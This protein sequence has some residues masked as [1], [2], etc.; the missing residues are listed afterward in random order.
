[1]T[2]LAACL[3]AL[4]V[5]LLLA[6]AGTAAAQSGKSEAAQRE[7]KELRARIADLTAEQR[8]SERARGD[9]GR[10]LREADAAVDAAARALRGAE[11]ALSAAQAELEQL[12]AR[13]AT[14]E[15][16]LQKQRKALAALLRSR[17]VLGQRPRLQ[18]LLEQERLGDLARALAYQRYFERDRARRMT[19]L[20]GELQAL[21]A[22]VPQVQARRE[23]LALARDQQ[24]QAVDALAAQRRERSQAV[25]KL[26]A[27]YKDRKVRLAA[28]GR[29]ERATERLLSRLQ[30]AMKRRTT[31]A[32]VKATARRPGDAKVPVAA[33]L[34]LPLTGTVLAGFGGVMPDGHRS[35]GLLIA[36]AA[37]AEVRAVAAGRVAYADWLKGYGLLLIVDHGDG[38]MSLYA[39]NDTLLKATG[40]AVRAG[41][42][43][44]TVGTSGGQARPAL[45]F[46]LRRGS[47][48]VDPA[49]F[50]RR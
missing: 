11:A 7:L 17:Y 5:G 19:A 47:Q 2:P 25:A 16:S 3:R 41:E 26:D 1:V 45:Y 50:L 31:T 13:Q 4:V 30:A 38:L 28:L 32:P 24:Q 43:V 46:E 8:A 10:E 14:L 33:N 12:V 22:L 20:A 6:C 27:K 42:A 36:G 39:F 49:G 40:D 34:R 23:A 29:D 35:Q 18:L 48:P 15:A 9:A 44:A 21:A 37:G